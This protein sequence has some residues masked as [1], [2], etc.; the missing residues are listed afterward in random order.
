MK[1]ITVG[2]ANR[3]SELSN[4][5]GERTLRTL[6]TGENK[7]LVRPERME[8]LRTGRGRLSES[9]LARLELVSRNANALSALKKRGSGKREFKVNRSLRD[10]V[11]TGKRKDVDYR[12]QD[13]PERED[14]LRAI[15]ALRYLGV[16]PSSGTF[17]VKKDR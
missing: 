1:R 11:T 7:R 14:Q 3:I 16:D 17:Y 12:A 8:N 2:E 13:Q 15:K 6:L 10:W 5:L 4:R 9:E